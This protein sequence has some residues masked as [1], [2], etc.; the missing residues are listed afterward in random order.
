MQYRRDKLNAMKRMLF[1]ARIEPPGF[2]LKLFAFCLSF[3]TSRA[4]PVGPTV[5]KG[6]AT[7][8]TQGPQFTVR[9]SESAF[10][11]WQSFNIGAGQTTRFIQPSA[12]S[13]V[14]N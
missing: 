9:T 12:S 8:T 7:F 3:I 14:F 11:N 4:N 1:H 13:V 10:I 2:V 5:T 6:T